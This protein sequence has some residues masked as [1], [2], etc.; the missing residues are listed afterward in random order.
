MGVE[1][2]HGY[3][4]LFHKGDDDMCMRPTF[5]GPGARAVCVK[6]SVSYH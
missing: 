6:R 2:L 5:E 4:D 1:S 3:F